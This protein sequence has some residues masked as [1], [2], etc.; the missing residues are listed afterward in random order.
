MSFYNPAVLL[1]IHPF[2]PISLHSVAQV[3]VYFLAFPRIQRHR[4]VGPFAL[5]TAPL[6]FWRCIPLAHLDMLSIGVLV[7]VAFWTPRKGALCISLV[8]ILSS[9]PEDP[10]MRV[11]RRRS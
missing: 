4:H 6:G 3:I 2:L 9:K 11:E 5:L 1:T 10:V 7:V 8:F